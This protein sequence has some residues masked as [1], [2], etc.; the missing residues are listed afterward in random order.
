MPLESCTRAYTNGSKLGHTLSPA[1]ADP[2]ADAIRKAAEAVPVVT[3]AAKNKSADVFLE[4]AVHTLWESE[5]AVRTPVGRLKIVTT[6]L[7]RRNAY[8]VLAAVATALV[9]NQD[10][11]ALSLKV[12]SFLTPN[13]L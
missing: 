8:N 13:H 10:G 5:L 7:G 9:L 4:K 6:L 1:F 12:C 2:H 11:E 3:Y